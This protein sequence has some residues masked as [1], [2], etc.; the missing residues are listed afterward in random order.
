[1]KNIV[2]LLINVFIISELAICQ[3]DLTLSYYDS[4]KKSDSSFNTLKTDFK[5]DDLGHRI[6]IRFG[7]QV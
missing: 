5:S 4:N 1:M 7:G 3:T 6:G 2:F